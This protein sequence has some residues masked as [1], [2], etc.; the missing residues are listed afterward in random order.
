MKRPLEDPSESNSPQQPQAKV[1]QI[2]PQM[3]HINFDHAMCGCRLCRTIESLNQYLLWLFSGDEDGKQYQSQHQTI[4]LTQKISEPRQTGHLKKAV[5]QPGAWSSEAV[6]E[7]EAGRGEETAV[8]GG[9]RG[10]R[11]GEE[12]GG[13]E[14]QNAVS[15]RTRHVMT[16]YSACLL[17]EIDAFVVYQ[18]LVHFSARPDAIA[19]K[20]RM[21]DSIRAKTFILQSV[22]VQL[23]GGPAEP[24]RDVPSRRL[25]QGFRQASEFRSF[26][27]KTK[28]R[29]ARIIP[30][31]SCPQQ[32]FRTLV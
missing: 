17:E 4:A 7:P 25:P 10:G 15:M 3:F 28:R 24:V 13:G 2:F 11:Q 8:R 23:H 20:R 1:T 29:R 27:F 12:A 21:S 30:F 6:P 5:A 22:G 9:Q 16:V 19:Q 31:E 14:A 32:S 18:L 26:L